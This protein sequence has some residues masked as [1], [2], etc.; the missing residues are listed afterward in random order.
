MQMNNYLKSVQNIKRS[1]F[2]MLAGTVQA[3]LPVNN[4]E[5]LIVRFDPDATVHYLPCL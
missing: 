4:G 5:S 2:Y 1:T 3:V